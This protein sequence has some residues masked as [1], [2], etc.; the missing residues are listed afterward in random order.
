MTLDVLH[1]V[2]S[3]PRDSIPRL[4]GVQF[5][6]LF[7]YFKKPHDYPQPLILLHANDLPDYLERGLGYGAGG[8][9]G[10]LH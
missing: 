2:S 10:F 7:D 3:L 5:L 6:S 8:L 4:P 9:Y 1:V